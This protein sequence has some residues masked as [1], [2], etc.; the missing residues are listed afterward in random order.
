M[1]KVLIVIIELLVFVT[2]FAFLNRLV[3]PKYT[4]SLVEGSLTSD[5]YKSGF[6]HDVL[7]FGDCE[8]YSNIS[9]D[10]MFENEGILVYNRSNAQQMMWQS[11]YLLEEALT[12]ETPKVVML[13]VGGLR[14]GVNEIDEAYNRLAIDKMKWS[15]Y[16]VDMIRESMKKDESIASYIFPIIRYHSR[17]DQ[18]TGED[19]KYLFD[20]PVVNYSGYIINTDVVPYT[21]FPVKRELSDYRFDEKSVTFMDRF[22]HLCKD[23]GINIILFKAPGLYPYWYDEWD[24]W[25]DSY[26]KDNGIVYLNYNLMNIGLDYSKDSYDGGMHLNYNGAYK[27]STYMST[28][29]AN[30]YNLTSHKG[31]PFYQRKL[32]NFQEA[33]DK[34][35]QISG[36]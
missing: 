28:Q 4:S 5:Y 23:K 2:I 13:S 32:F 21:S 35:R 18:L 14:N 22:V 27:L 12:Y 19:L 6:N 8:V 30:L 3:A 20:Q 36:Q 17:V 16:K 15:S 24:N 34:A 33:V 11:Y 1:K 9:P 26:A 31:D 25:V 29:L 7:I 10:I